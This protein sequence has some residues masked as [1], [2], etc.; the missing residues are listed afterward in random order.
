MGIVVGMVGTID[1][2][3]QH[4]VAGCIAK[5]NSQEAKFVGVKFE[6]FAFREPIFAICPPIGLGNVFGGDEVKADVEKFSQLE[7]VGGTYPGC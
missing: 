4:D 1:I 5:A 3:I 6:K 2:D 7:Q